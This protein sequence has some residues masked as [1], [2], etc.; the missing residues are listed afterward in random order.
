MI[1][2]FSAGPATVYKEA[3]SE[4]QESFLDFMHHGAHIG[5]S[6]VES[7]HRSA[8]YDELH[9]NAIN[10]LKTLLGLDDT[11]TVL[12]LAGGASL[13]FAMLPYNFLLSS[14]KPTLASYYKTGAWANTAIRNANT[15]LTSHQNNTDLQNAEIDIVYDGSPHNFTTLPDT[16]EISFNEHSTYVHLTSNETIEGIQWKTFP[17]TGTIPLVADMSSDILSRRISTKQFSLMYAGAQKNIGIAGVTV[18]I[19]KNE[20]LNSAYTQLPDYLSYQVHANKNSLFNTPPVFSIWVLERVLNHIQSLG[21]VSAV[22]ALNT[23]K[24]DTLYDFIDQSNGFYYSPV[25]DK[26]VRSCMNVVFKIHDE[27]LEPIFIKQAT[28]EGLVGLKGHRSVGG[29]RASIY[30]AMSL[31]GVQALCSFMNMFASQHG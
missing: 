13:Q 16:K 29:L 18:V 24:A 3:L 17:D 10:I 23:Q 8:I 4:V 20:F 21:G 27:S 6:L 9:N 11:Y 15:V 25:Q 19:I 12:L 22:E 30:N 31:E 5:Y 1:Y 28:Q 7:S 14:S 2:N 26:A